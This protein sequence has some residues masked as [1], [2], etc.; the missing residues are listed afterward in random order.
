MFVI[1][2]LPVLGM[3]LWMSACSHTPNEKVVCG[4]VSS[5]LPPAAEQDLFRAI[6]TH[7]DGQP[8]I[9]RPNYQLQPGRYV[10]TLAE[11]ILD[12]RLQ[13]RPS[14]RVVKTLEIQVAQ[15]QRYHLAAKLNTDKIYIGDDQ[16]FWLPV[17]RL[18]ENHQC[19]IHT[20]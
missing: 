8:V 19:E 10:F 9:S 17:V 4:T 7:I 11:L 12:H 13:V 1:R 16:G 3:L 2:V 15:D 5:Y 18:E 14:A 6:V 20:L